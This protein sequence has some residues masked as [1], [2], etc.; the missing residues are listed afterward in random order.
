M[1]LK[2]YNTELTEIKGEYCIVDQKLIRNPVNIL[3]CVSLRLPI[4]MI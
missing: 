4:E 1:E 3:I 2:E